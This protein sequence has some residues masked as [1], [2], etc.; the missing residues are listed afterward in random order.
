MWN[1]AKKICYSFKY[2]RHICCYNQQLTYLICIYICIRIKQRIFHTQFVAFDE[3]RN[4]YTYIIYLQTKYFL[5]NYLDSGQ[6]WEKTDYYVCTYVYMYVYIWKF[7]QT[8]VKFLQEKYWLLT[9]I[10]LVSSF[11]LNSSS[12]ICFPYK[13]LIFLKRH[14][15]II[16]Q[17]YTS[18]ILDHLVRL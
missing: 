13:Q 6:D 16:H 2:V 10:Q 17:L 8:Y 5:N 14:C 11:A 4:T 7:L 3:I 1:L 18:C 12:S 9:K 15:P